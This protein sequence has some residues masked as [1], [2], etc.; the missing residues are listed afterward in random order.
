MKLIYKR[1]KSLHKLYRIF[2][3]HPRY[4]HDILHRRG[5]HHGTGDILIML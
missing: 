2:W 3:D 1:L 4:R 5:R